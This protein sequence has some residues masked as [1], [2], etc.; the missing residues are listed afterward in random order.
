MAPSVMARLTH[1]WRTKACAR[2]TGSLAGL[3]YRSL[4]ID[5]L[6][7]EEPQSG[8]ADAALV[9]VGIDEATQRHL[10]A[11][12]DGRRVFLDLIAGADVFVTN[13]RMDALE[14][15]GLD[16]PVLLTHNPRLVYGIITG[17]G[18]EGE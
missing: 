4:W 3:N 11:T 5:S 14:R 13:I 12:D 15:L 6:D 17:Y 10:L 9:A 8:D 2:L 18:L 7:H 1:R 16:A